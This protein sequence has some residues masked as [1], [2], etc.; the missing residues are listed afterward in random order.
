MVQRLH[1]AGGRAAYVPN[2]VVTHGG[3][4]RANGARPPPL[5]PGP[6]PLHGTD[7]KPRHRQHDRGRVRLD[8]TT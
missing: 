7:D 6:R 2:V 5:A 3:P 1:D 8:A 4:A